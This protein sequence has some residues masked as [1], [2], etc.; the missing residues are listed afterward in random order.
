[1]A[2]YTDWRQDHT[3]PH[4]GGGGSRKKGVESMTDHAGNLI[5]SGDIIVLVETR[6]EH[7]GYGWEIMSRMRVIQHHPEVFV[8]CMVNQNYAILFHLETI[9]QKSPDAIVCIEG[10]SDNEIEYYLKY[11]EA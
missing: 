6:N 4:E 2:T 1:M 11:F 7:G 9:L 5:K 3:V 10:K 8:E